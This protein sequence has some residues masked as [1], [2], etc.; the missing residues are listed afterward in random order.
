MSKQ[1]QQIRTAEEVATFL[2]KVKEEFVRKYGSTEHEG[3]HWYDKVVEVGITTNKVEVGGATSW[4][5]DI[6]VVI[7]S[8]DGKKFD[9]VT[10]VRIID[11]IN[12]RSV[13]P[14]SEEDMEE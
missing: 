5:F 14:R 9:K 2:R 10:S 11:E 3:N 4:W 8:S 13:T 6:A 1:N 12:G 7:P